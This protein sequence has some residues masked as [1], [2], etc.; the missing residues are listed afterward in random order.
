MSNIVVSLASNI[1]FEAGMTER[2]ALSLC[3]SEGIDFGGIYRSFNRTGCWC[4]PLGGKSG[5]YALYRYSSHLWS[6]LGVLNDI[7]SGSSHPVLDLYRYTYA[8]LTRKF[9]SQLF[10]F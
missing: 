7:A 8:S 9:Q 4:C 3:Y 1:R 6:A 2:Q 5:F 10:W